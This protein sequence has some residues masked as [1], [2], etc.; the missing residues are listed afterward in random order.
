VGCVRAK[1]SGRQVV[2]VHLLGAHVTS[3]RFAEARLRV[4]MLVQAQGTG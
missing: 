2:Y 1:L 3:G 4:R